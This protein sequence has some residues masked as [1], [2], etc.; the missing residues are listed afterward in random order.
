MFFLHMKQVNKGNKSNMDY[1]QTP[2]KDYESTLATLC[3]VFQ[4]NMYSFD[5]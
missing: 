2:G 4:L 1:N 3:H 5:V